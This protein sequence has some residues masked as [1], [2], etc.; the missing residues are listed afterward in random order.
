MI[1]N[2]VEDEIALIQGFTECPRYM[3]THLV[4]HQVQPV[5]FCVDFVIFPKNNVSIKIECSFFFCI[6]YTHGTNR[7]LNMNAIS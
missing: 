7:I 3:Y 2:K 1:R 5:T 6:I 4:T